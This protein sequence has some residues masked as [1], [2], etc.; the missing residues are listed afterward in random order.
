MN[1][2]G[3]AN[4]AKGSF[5][6]LDYNHGPNWKTDVPLMDQDVSHHL[7]YVTGLFAS[8][9]LIGGGPVVEE[10]RGM[11]LIKTPHRAM[12]EGIVQ[13]DPAVKAGVFEVTI[14]EWSPDRLQPL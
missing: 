1:G 9:R 6:V 12:A 3:H 2:F 5:F 11:Y 4:K 7:S 8:G 10:N 13:A 14:R